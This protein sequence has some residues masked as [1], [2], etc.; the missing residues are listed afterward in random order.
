MKRKVISIRFSEDELKKIAGVGE[1][2]STSESVRTFIVRAVD[3]E[4]AEA[5]KW[6]ELVRQIR[7]VSEQAEG[8]NLSHYFD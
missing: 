2:K 7:D 4:Q 3:A 8:C 5:E 1:G 6:S